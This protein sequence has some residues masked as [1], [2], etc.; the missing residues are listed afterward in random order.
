[1]PETKSETNYCPCG[2]PKTLAECCQPIIQGARNAKTAEDLLRARYTAFTLG[3]VPF[4]LSSHHSKTRKDVNE[5]EITDWSKNSE[6]LGLKILQKEAGNEKDTQGTIIFSADYIAEGKK[7]EHA[8]KSLFE[9]EDGQW[10][11]LDA[12]RVQIGTYRR[13]EPKVGRNDP[14]ICG[15]GKKFKKCCAGKTEAAAG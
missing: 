10:R 7:H 4:I 1:M 6:W 9:K 5:E 8:E 15:S 14:C 2:S 11:F 3:A 12:Q 13:A